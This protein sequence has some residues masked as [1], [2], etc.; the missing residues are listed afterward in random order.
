MS[1]WKY[2]MLK[3]GQINVPVIFS[4]ILI[5]SKVDDA[6]KPMLAGKAP[7]KVVGA[8]MIMGLTVETLGAGSVSLGIN[9]RPED[10]DIV[11]TYEDN[12]GV[13]R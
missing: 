6:I 3:V 10:K 7:A 9:A 1:N 5:H 13:R 4:D 11:N 8:G 12:G 2:V